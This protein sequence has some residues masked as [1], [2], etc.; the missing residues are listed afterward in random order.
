MILITLDR[1][2]RRSC[3]GESGED[4]GVNEEEVNEVS[5][6]P[7]HHFNAHAGKFERPFLY[8]KSR[9]TWS[10][11]VGMLFRSMTIQPSHACIRFSGTHLHSCKTTINSKPSNQISVLLDVPFPFPVPSITFP[12]FL[13]SVHTFTSW[14]ILQHTRY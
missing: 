12:L 9:V 5:L 10:R 14:D 6:P 3:R 1:S 4:V 2:E 11:R 13:L 7:F 8:E